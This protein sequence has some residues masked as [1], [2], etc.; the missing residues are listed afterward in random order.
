MVGKIEVVTQQVFALIS[1]QT[2]TLESKEG[3]LRYEALDR[4]L[5]QEI[6]NK[7]GRFG[8]QETDWHSIED[9]WPNRTRFLE[10]DASLVS[11]DLVTSLQSLLVGQY[12]SWIVNINVYEGLSSGA[13]VHI[14]PLNVYAS[15]CVCTKE[16]FLIF[17][18]GNGGRPL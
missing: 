3:E 15:K 17:E 7:M 13:A 8:V 9:W 2:E 5:M 18:R 1:Q 14:G 4:S 16:V 10:V 12:G 11:T 6:S